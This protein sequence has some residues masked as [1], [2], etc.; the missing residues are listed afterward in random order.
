[1]QRKCACG[2]HTIA[3][4]ECAGCRKKR[5]S[6]QRS[7]ANQAESTS[8]PPI[9]HD[10]LRSPSR[11][12]D[13]AT[14][15]FFESRFAHDFS[16][17]RVHTDAKAAESA[18]AVNAVAFTVGRNVVF[19]EGQYAPETMTGRRVLAHELTHVVQQQRQHG[20]QQGSLRISSSND[21][22]ERQADKISQN[23]ADNQHVG[24][25]KKISQP[26][27]QR[28]LARP[29]RGVPAPI[30]QLTPEQIQEAI[31]FNENRFSDPYSIRVIR[32]V[33]GLAPVPV[34]VDEAL[35]QAV[36]EW[37]AARHMTQDGK[38]G[39]RTTRSIYFELVA[40]RQYRD[41][42]F[43]LMDS[44]NLPGSL[45][46]RD[47]RVATGPLCCGPTGR[48]DA[49]TFG[50]PHCP[51]IGGP[52]YI[53]FCRTHIPQTIADYDHFVRIVGH[54]LIH[55]PQ[56]AAGT[57]NVDVDEFEGFFWEACAR[58]RAPQLSAAERV[59]H[60]LT[61]RAHFALI[62]PALRTPA[63]IAMRNQLI[64]LIAAGGVGPCL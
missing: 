11:A 45:R 60:A 49:L 33:L 28:D 41:A 19:G 17:V 38:V 48:A 9:V 37:Q 64:R 3:G 8:V 52:I 5:L 56:C 4:G 54:E 44:Y 40:E 53:C 18:Q 58:G 32:D 31:E 7:A 63:R 22:F 10:V 25:I 13:P 43:L 2:Q 6:L 35:I 27:V 29:P 16:D 62:P 57:G 61:A 42:I 34:V 55:V 46:L 47:V 39:H 36:V 20:L 30:R 21:V 24:T 12:L 26:V 23:I 14:R 59:G 1:M 15:T 50:G 51:P